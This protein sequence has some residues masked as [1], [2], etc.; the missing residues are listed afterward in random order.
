MKDSLDGMQPEGFPEPLFVRFNRQKGGGQ[1]GGGGKS[2]G[3]ATAGG[4]WDGGESAPSD[5]LYVRG[6]PM[7]CTQ[8]SITEDFSA[9][10]P[11]TSVKVLEPPPGATNK[12]AMIRFLSEA[13]ASFVKDSLD[14]TQP[15]GFPEP[16]VVRFNRGKGKG[17]GK[18]GGADAWSWSGGG[19]QS[20]SERFQ[21]TVRWFNDRGFGMICQDAG[22]NDV[23][24]LKTD[25]DAG[26]AEPLDRVSYEVGP[27]EK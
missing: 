4:G 14:G 25:I 3:T 10:R 12:A 22:G 19:G 21:G 17:K 9:M 13:D 1:K 7:T 6:L 11:V 18:G 24:V 5:N 23:F 16:L 8:E 26:W 15:D 20:Q 27:N 2:D